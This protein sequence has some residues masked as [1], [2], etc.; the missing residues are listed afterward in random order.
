VV[1]TPARFDRA[2]L[3]AFNLDAIQQMGEEAFLVRLREHGAR[4]HP[5]FLAALG[6]DGLA[7]LARASKPRSKTLDEPF[8]LNA[9]LV[10]PDDSIRWERSKAVDKALWR[11]SPAGA[12]LLDRLKPCLES[13]AAWEEVALEAIATAFAA[14]HA[15]GNLGAVA[16]PLRIAVS[17]GTVS[18][19][20]FDTLVLLGRERTLR[21]LDRCLGWCR[22]AASR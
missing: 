13:A 2:K 7:R 16:Q 18:P 15:G 4:H 5:A 21:R 8:R 22:E 19:P 1:R 6:E 12:E 3:L 11:G 10:A 9:F 17:G 20:I 14:Q